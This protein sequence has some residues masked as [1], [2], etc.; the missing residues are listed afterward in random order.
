MIKALILFAATA[1]RAAAA[2]CESGKLDA[3][4]GTCCAASCTACGAGDGCLAAAQRARVSVCHDPTDVD[5]VVPHELDAAA[6]AKKREQLA[7]KE[8]KR[9]ASE[10]KKAQQRARHDAT[11]AALPLTE[12]E[13]QKLALDAARN[14]AKR[15]ASELKKRL[16]REKHDAAHADERFHLIN[17][18]FK[19]AAT[20][21]AACHALGCEHRHGGCFHRVKGNMP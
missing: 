18:A 2:Y 10:E 20:T 12:D 16:Q 3:A 4:T 14:A 17:C 5:C 13:R 19:E 21:P 7:R 9:L 15:T 11:H 8:A 1:A 6:A